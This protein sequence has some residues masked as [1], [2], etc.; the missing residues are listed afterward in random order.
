MAG[1][2]QVVVFDVNE[3]LSDME[4]LRAVFTAA[5]APAGM[6]DTW[7]A[8]TLRDGFALA[9]AGSAASFP[10]VAGGAMRLL[11]HAEPDLT[12]PVDQI[13]AS[14]L[15]GFR[16]LELHPDVAAGMRVLVDGGV[17]LVTL[18][19]GSAALAATLFRN[20]GLD[21][22]VE[23]RLTVDDA[24][25]W[26]PHPRSYAHAVERCGVPAESM[27]M[28][29]VHPWDTDGAKRAGLRSAWL[30]RGGAPYPGVFLAP[31]VTAADLPAL[32]REV[33]AL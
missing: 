12:A 19:N 11:L 22:L 1:Q 32:A 2:V 18:T 9:A 14:V 5:G 27:C 29:A 13:V 10:E 33:L 7:F 26:K 15:E 31:D 30:D 21:D 28:V 25:R 4:P 3:T 17:R 6:L 16:G 24:G 23:Q 20:A 8:S